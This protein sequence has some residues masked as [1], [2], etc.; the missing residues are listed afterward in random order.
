MR[1]DTA[2]L[3]HPFANNAQRLWQILWTN[4]QQR[5]K[6]DKQ[7]FGRRDVKHSIGQSGGP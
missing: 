3:A 5:H 7:Q 6:D 2:C 4:N 1:R